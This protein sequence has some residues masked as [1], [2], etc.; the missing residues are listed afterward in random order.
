MSFCGQRRTFVRIDE[1]TNPEWGTAPD[2][3]PIET[4]VRYGFVI[5]DKPRGP[6]SHETVAWLKR[7]VGLERA[8]HAGTLDPGVSG[9]LPV[10][11]GEGT[12]VLQAITRADK[13]YVAVMKLHEDVA[14][15]RIR[16]VF[17]EF[18][19]R[20][21]Q[22]PPMRSAV[23]RQLREKH[24]YSLELLEKSGKYVLMRA[25]VE[26]GTYIRKLVHDIGE[27]LGVGAN[28]RELRRVRVACFDEEESVTLHDV[29]DALYIWRNYDDESLL[30]SVVRPIEEITRHLP[31][32][33]IR[34]TSVDAVC[35]GA[36]LAAPGIAKVEEGITRDALVAIMSLKGELVALGRALMDTQAMLNVSRGIAV[37]TTRVLMR[38][39]TY[40]A[41]WKK[42]SARA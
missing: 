1:G 20:I 32:V 36:P 18:T 34:D 28:M 23:K 22:R 33:W 8:G 40:P 29:N 2:K 11:L 13:V 10:A 41:Y 19:G 38:P 15:D 35:H 31:K 16:E 17:A 39:G 21:Y 14:E 3:R 12:K 25:H 30:R 27:V 5:L 37:K 26:S 6:T 24:V 42:R 4:Y 9:V 7:L